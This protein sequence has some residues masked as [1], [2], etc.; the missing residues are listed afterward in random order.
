MQLRRDIG[1]RLILFCNYRCA[2]APMPA[3]LRPWR[4]LTACWADLASSNSIPRYT[5][6]PFDFFSAVLRILDVYPGS[7]I[8]LFSIPDLNFFHPRSR[9]HM[10]EFKNFN[11]KNCCLSSRKYDPGCSSRIRIMIFTH[12]ESRIQGSKRHR[13]L[14][15]DP[16]H[17][18]SE[19]NEITEVT[20]KELLQNFCHYS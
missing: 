20:K 5:V 3:P 16:Q 2:T 8:R 9:I 15:P 19:I 1:K 7:Q 13:I 6:W 4:A 17:C 12:P 18:F 11:P 10:K 14:D